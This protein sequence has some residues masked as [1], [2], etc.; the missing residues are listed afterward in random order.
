[1]SHYAAAGVDIDAATRAVDLMK[2]AVRRTYTSS[3]LADV[4]S[5][6][7]LFA[8]ENL[9]SQPVLVASTDG[10]GTKVKLAAQLGRWR[11]VGHDIVNHCVNDILVQGARPLFFLDYIATSKLIPEAVAEVVTGIAEA[12]E[13]VGCALL[14]GETAEMP[15]VYAEGAFDVA[16]TVIGLVDRGAILPRMDQMEAGDLLVG[17]PSS[18]PH[19]NGYS[20]IRRIVEDRDLNELIDGLPLADRLLA[21]HRCYLP[22]YQ[23]LV[24]AGILVKGMAHLTGGG[25]VDNIPRVLPGGLAARIDRRGWDHPLLFG[26]LVE[27]SGMDEAEA[28]RVFNMGIGMVLIVGNDEIAPLQRTLPEAR[29]IGTL[30]ERVD[31]V[32]ILE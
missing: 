11:G 22:H 27:W 31:A 28:Y 2:A 16:G 7:G 26:K 20:L 5:F 6:G 4:G 30:V 1:M 15:G 3:V 21:P 32:V 17:L 29:I 24:D 23:K 14:G 8:L 19:T 18:G 9:P 25:F 13:A 12:C 10:V